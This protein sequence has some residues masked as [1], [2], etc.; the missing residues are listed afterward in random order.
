MQGH[1]KQWRN[2]FGSLFRTP[3]RAL[4]TAAVIAVI[5]FSGV[6][7]MLVSAFIKNVFE[8]LLI[9]AF[10]IALLLYIGNSGKRK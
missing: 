4:L 5:I 8:P 3:G 1:S 7:S 6:I 10:L 9:L 2:F